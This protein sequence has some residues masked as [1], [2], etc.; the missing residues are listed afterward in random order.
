[1]FGHGRYTIDNPDEKEE[2]EIVTFKIQPDAI[3]NMWLTT[4]ILA[5]IS[6]IVSVILWCFYR[7]NSQ[8]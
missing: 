8:I 5:A 4:T 1:M 7:Q 6:I 3:G 2:I